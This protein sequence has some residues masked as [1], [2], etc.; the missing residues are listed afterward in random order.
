MSSITDILAANAT[1]ASAAASKSGIAET[2]ERFL[3]MLIAQMKNQDPL[4][5]LDNA[6]VT[7]QMA[8]LSTVQGI[9]KMY[10]ALESLAASMGTSQAS[11]AAGLIGHVVLAPGNGVSPDGSANVV[12]FELPYGVDSLTAT[13]KNASGAI[14]RTLDL[15]ARDEGIGM[16]SWD[17]LDDSGNAVS[18]DAAYTFSLTAVQ[19]GQAVDVTTLALGQVASVNLE[20]G[21][22]MLDLGAVGSTAYEGV[23]RIY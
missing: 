16:V 8:Q 1:P 2:Q 23:R 10:Q 11:Q 9:E 3:A 13:I 20:G 19:S 17:G 7:S 6:Q 18:P 14:V 5:P 21:K 4:N 12:G 22:V 15:G